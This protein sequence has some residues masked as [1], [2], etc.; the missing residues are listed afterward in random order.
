MPFSAPLRKHRLD[1][2]IFADL[3]QYIHKDEF[4]A[5]GREGLSSTQ[6]H[7]PQSM[8]PVREYFFDHFTAPEA[9]FFWCYR[10]ATQLGVDL[11]GFPNVTAH[12]KRMQERPNVKKLIAYEKEVNER[13]AKSASVTIEFC[14]HTGV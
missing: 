9:H 11:S 2:W 10:R 1:E 6:Q 12:F 4:D 3:H 8:N 7:C 5:F 14:R 13:F